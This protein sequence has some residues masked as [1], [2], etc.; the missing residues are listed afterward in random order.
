MEQRIGE[1]YVLTEPIHPLADGVM[2]AGKDLS[3]HRDVFLL[4]VEKSGDA[5]SS[6]YLRVLGQ[7]AQFSDERFFH[8][9]NAGLAENHVYTVLTAQKGTPLS[10]QL[11]RHRMRGTEIVSAVFD[12]GKG[13][14]EAMEEG[15]SG[16]SVTA[17]NMWLTE[18]NRLK[19]MNYWSPGKLVS[20]GSL[21]LCT[22]LYQISTHSKQGPATFDQYQENVVPSLT[23]LTSGQKEALLALSRRVF[24]EE[25]SLSSFIFSLREIIA[26]EKS[27]EAPPK[28]FIPPAAPPAEPVRETAPPRIQY[29]QEE[30]PAPERV[31]RTEK[32]PRAKEP[33]AEEADTREKMPLRRTIWT[34]GTVA[35][36]LLGLAV[37]MYMLLPGGPSKGPGSGGTAGNTA[38][39]TP[40]PTPTS[41]V[42]TATPEPTPTPTPAT[43]AVPGQIP[44]LIGMTQEAAEQAVKAAGMRYSYFIE[45]NPA[46][47]GTVFRQE[48]AP[49]QPANKG[50]RV[51]FYISKGQ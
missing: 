16:F 28:A 29:R 35:V 50:D 31:R 21:G 47:S 44:N 24:R 12:L 11:G 27:P 17:E 4:M 25:V 43:E 26:L 37:F 20:R 32:P 19:V 38:T 46:E 2:Y 13:M 10:A 7:A 22:L 3:L 30:E 8:I 40:A 18:D 1:R 23:G 48:P 34:L 45:P 36:V 42:N 49:N 41:T 51:T 14:Q 33:E 39:A 6:D 5:S 15:I 9:L